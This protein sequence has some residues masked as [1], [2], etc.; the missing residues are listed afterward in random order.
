MK[1]TRVS[2]YVGSYG[3]YNEGYLDGKWM[4]PADYSTL[5][6]FIE[7]CHELFGDENDRLELMFQDVENL[8]GSLYD[9][10]E[11]TEE[12]FD[13]AKYVDDNPDLAEAAY[14]YADNYQTWDEQDFEDR[15][16]GEYASLGDFAYDFIQEVG[17][18]AQAVSDP[19][20]YFD[21]DQ[22]GKELKWDMDPEDDYDAEFLEM[23]DYD[24]GE[25]YFEENNILNN[26]PETVEAYF[27]YDKFGQDLEYSGDI[28]YVEGYVFQSR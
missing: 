12:A 11:F 5:T 26:S 6:D 7:A 20:V 1:S 28:D 15:Y 24:C 9:E 10:G 14:A 18:I 27:D 21:F 2:V 4:Y 13:F 8:P 22:F 25:R 17:G 16:R 3:G 19:E 23:S